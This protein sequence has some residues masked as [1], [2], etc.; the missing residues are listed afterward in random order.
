[1]SPYLVTFAISLLSL[2]LATKT[3]NKIIRQIF[4]IVAIMTPSLLAGLRDVSIGSDTGG[5]PLVTYSYVSS[6]KSLGQ[7]IM[8]N[9][10]DVENAYVA[11]AYYS[12]HIINLFNFFLTC[13][14]LITIASLFWG[15]KV[16]KENIVWVFFLFFFMYYNTT[17]NAQRQSMALCMCVT[18][19]AY[20][21]RKNYLMTGIT[22][23]LAFSFHHSAVLF[24][25]VIFLYWFVQR[26]PK[27][28]RSIKMQIGVIILIIVVL[29]SFNELVQSLVGIGLEE[30]YA[31]RY[32]NSEEYGSNIPIS[33]FAL[34][35][36][37]LIAFLSVAYKDKKSNYYIFGKYMMII[38]LLLCFAGLISTFAVRIDAYFMFVNILLLSHYLPNSNSIWKFFT[39]CFYI[40]YWIM[41][42]VVA[43]LA[44]SYPYK[45]IILSSII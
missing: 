38:A 23:L 33:L 22:F 45:S 10:G 42:T 31:D 11:I 32:G 4:Y 2:Y 37:N 43:N 20:M 6:M 21:M 9:D 41:I 30:K 34:N 8:W 13:I 44:D 19:I 16:S 5:Y 40:F 15:V 18:C 3:T 17:L 7:A 14:A 39:V 26:F 36:F 1:M 28:S 24:I 12:S 29:V 35:S 25:S 27:F